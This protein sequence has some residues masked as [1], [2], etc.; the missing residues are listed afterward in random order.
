MCPEWWLNT[1]LVGSAVRTLTEDPGNQGVANR[2]E[3]VRTA[4]PTGFHQ[5]GHMSPDLLVRGE[6]PHVREGA[7]CRARGRDG[8]GRDEPRRHPGP[9][10]PDSSPG[11][12]APR[13]D[14]AD[15]PHAVRGRGERRGGSTGVGGQ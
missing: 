9:V 12:R 1:A 11:A 2:A 10:H 8:T 15:P 4:D 3:M 6:V 13:L 7:A 14:P 5:S